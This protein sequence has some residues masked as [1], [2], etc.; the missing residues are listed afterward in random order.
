MENEK[1]LKEIISTRV[2][3]QVKK[4]EQRVSIKD[5]AE[6]QHQQSGK[7]FCF[8]HP[9]YKNVIFHMDK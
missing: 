7:L 1:D 6:I 9:I 4:I 8:Y 3:N 5:F 2:I